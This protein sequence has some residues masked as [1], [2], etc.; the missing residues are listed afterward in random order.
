MRTINLNNR[1]GSGKKDKKSELRGGF[2]EIEL[3]KIE[4]VF[5]LTFCISA[6]DTNICGNTR[7]F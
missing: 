4:S 5:V 2:F 6:P 7:T 3:N 1:E